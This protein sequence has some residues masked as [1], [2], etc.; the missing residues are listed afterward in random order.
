[1][2]LDLRATP[3]SECRVRYAAVRP[4]TN[5]CKRCTQKYRE[6]ESAHT[7]RDR[8]RERRG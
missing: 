8:E 5:G 6:S 4:P 3:C 1:M 7:R 2:K